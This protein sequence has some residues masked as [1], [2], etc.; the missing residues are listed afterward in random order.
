MN[1]PSLQLSTAATVRALT[2]AGLVWL[3]SLMANNAHAVIEEGLHVGI[4]DFATVP[5]SAGGNF[6]SAR[7]NLLTTDPL[8]RIFVNDQR[9]PMYMYSNDGSSRSDYLDLS[10]YPGMSLLSTGEAG[11]QSF[12][13]HPDFGNSGTDGFGKFYTI[14]STTNRT[15]APT[16]PFVSNTGVTSGNSHDTL[17][18]EWMVPDPNADTYAAGG[19]VAPREVLRLEQPA[20][21]HNAGLVAFNPYLDSLDS[22]Y[23]NLYVAIGDGGSGNDPWNIARDPN[24]PYGKILRIDPLDPNGA[25]AYT[26][27][28]DN[29]FATDGNA[30]TLAE[31]YAYGLRNPQRFG[32][33]SATGNMYLADIGQGAFEEINLVVNGGNYGWD[34]EEGNSN[35]LDPSL[36]DPIAQYNRNELPDPELDPIVVLTGGSAITAGEVVRGS[37]VP[38]LNGLLLAGDFPRGI[39]LAIDVSNGPPAQRSGSDPFAELILI[40]VDGSGQPVDFINLINA[41]RVANGLPVQNRADLR[42]SHNVDGRVF[43]TNKKD[44]VIREIVAIQPGDFDF[45]NDA[46]ARDLLA[47][48]RGES[49]LP[50]SASD[51]AL[52]EANFGDSFPLAS[53]A[54]PVPEPSALLLFIQIGLMTGSIKRRHPAGPRR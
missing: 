36:D 45:D 24:K 48:Q 4:R 20:G 23:G 18:L 19:G 10:T 53:S 16:Y 32:W 30:A 17:L 52:W 44:G 35:P 12:A 38:G 49:P 5:D 3:F 47:W 6:P 46:D 34:L 25:A 2:Y 11:F 7:V 9:G 54:L 41:T 31:V 39:P 14:H 15:P 1:S 40:D 37:S 8:G 51:L 21:N 13:F 26:P 42:W 43:V 22:D 50:F 33:D 27:A 29:F 28:A